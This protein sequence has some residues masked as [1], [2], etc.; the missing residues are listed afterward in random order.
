MLWTDHSHYIHKQM[1]ARI[2]D[3]LGGGANLKS[4]EPNIGTVMVSSSGVISKS[5]F[6]FGGG[7]GAEDKN[8]ASPTLFLPA[9]PR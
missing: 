7:G 9:G 4:C 3:F 2:Q 6:F 8:L 1:Q 5:F